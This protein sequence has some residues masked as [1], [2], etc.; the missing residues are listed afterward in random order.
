MYAAKQVDFAFA[1]DNATADYGAQQQQQSRS[2][3]EARLWANL[4]VYSLDAG[5]TQASAPLLMDILSAFHKGQCQA[6]LPLA[7]CVS[8]FP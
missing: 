3:R 1:D 5:N 7:G 6:V 2:A 4:F 8:R